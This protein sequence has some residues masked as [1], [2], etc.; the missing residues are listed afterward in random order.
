VA[1][2]V[3]TEGSGWRA[4][5][6]HNGRP[7]PASNMRASD[8]D[9]EAVVEILRDAVAHGR[10]DFAEF[11]ERA[12]R[13]YAARTFGDLQPLTSDL[14]DAASGPALPA[15]D[16]GPIL[17]V[18]THENRRGRWL[19]PPRLRVSAVAGSVELDFCEAVL[20]AHQISIEVKVFLGSITLIVPDGVEVRVHG[21]AVLG[22]RSSRLR[23]PSVAD[24]PIIDVHG[25]VVMGSV[26]VRPPS[27]KRRRELGHRPR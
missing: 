3:S 7:V 12:A 6:G 22:S 2:V 24:A 4:L 10:L 13:A 16:S 15:L 18:L 8:A 17:V 20:S 11:D 26:D 21:T 25:V 27:K 14:P 5:L 9:R 19:V 1:P 23:R